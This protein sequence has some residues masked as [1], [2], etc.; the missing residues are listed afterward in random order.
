MK[1]EKDI[2]ALRTI[3]V[4]E[5]RSFDGFADV[6]DEQAIHIIHTLK[7]LSLLTHNIVTNHEKSDSISKLRKAE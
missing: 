2:T 5:L 6:S 3:S 1:I 7:E 4:K